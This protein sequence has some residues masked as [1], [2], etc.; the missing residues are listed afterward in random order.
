MGRFLIRDPNFA[1]AKGESGQSIKG[2]KGDSI[3]GDRG[4]PGL[5]WTGPYS[6][7]QTYQPG[8]VASYDGSSFVALREMK[9]RSPSDDGR[10]WQLLASKGEQG[11]NETTVIRHGSPRIVEAVAR[12][13]ELEASIGQGGSGAI[14][15]TADVPLSLGAVVYASGPDRI[16]AAKADAVETS[17]PIGVTIADIAADEVGHY[18]HDGIV[19]NESWSLTPNAI[20]YLSA[21]VAGGITDTAPDTS[22]QFVIVIGTAVSPTRLLVEIHRAYSIG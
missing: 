15:A 11:R 21:D 19:T 12:M 9:G 5:R 7:R 18:V 3:K 22:G 10:Y 16:D 2:D 13:D 6:A 20:Y 17:V 1:G 4:E 14:P 8:D